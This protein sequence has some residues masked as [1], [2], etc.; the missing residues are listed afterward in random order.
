MAHPVRTA[1]SCHLIWQT[2]SQNFVKN[3]CGK[4]H[5]SRV[6]PTDLRAVRPLIKLNAAVT[7]GRQQEL[8]QNKYADFILFTAWDLDR[9]GENLTALVRE[10]CY[11]GR[12]PENDSCVQLYEWTHCRSY[13]RE[14]HYTLKYVLTVPRGRCRT[15]TWAGGPQIS[16][17]VT[18]HHP[19]ACACLFQ[20]SGRFITAPSY[21]AY[22]SFQRGY[23]KSCRTRQ[24]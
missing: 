6:R 10:S 3:C 12:A 21:D 13:P 2:G 15:L 22:E 11:S 18:S 19:C 8:L 17:G 5:Y 14:F 7:N 9:V 20:S 23:S 24:L 4:F 1:T 16:S